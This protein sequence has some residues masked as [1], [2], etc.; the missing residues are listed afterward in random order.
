MPKRSAGIVPFRDRAGVL[1]V[2][3]VH[4]GGPFWSKKDDGAWS[5]PKGEIDEGEDALQAATREMEEETGVTVQGELIPLGKFRQPTGKTVIAWAMRAEIDPAS[6]KSGTFVLE[7]PP[8]SGR[9]AEF[10]EIDRAAWWSL[11]EA[12]RKI[13]RGQAPLLRTLAR[14]VEIGV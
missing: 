12:E 4:P 13:L 3:L 7:W 1:E 2:L 9:R 10:P 6:I 11:P 14:L 5:I 8:H